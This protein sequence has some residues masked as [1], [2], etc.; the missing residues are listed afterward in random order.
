MSRNGRLSKW[1]A[2]LGVPEDRGAFCA[3]LQSRGWVN[4]CARWVNPEGPRMG[5]ASQAKDPQ[6]RRCSSAALVCLSLFFT[7]AFTCSIFPILPTQLW[8]K[9]VQLGDRYHGMESPGPSTPWVTDTTAVLDG[10]LV[11]RQASSYRVGLELVCSSTCAGLFPSHTF[12][13]TALACCHFFFTAATTYTISH[14]K[15]LW[16]SPFSPS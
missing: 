7:A 16:V 8:L 12:C 2:G 10:H 11:Q 15:H 5:R 4:L 1:E 9:W 14:L 6:P 3:F 13:A